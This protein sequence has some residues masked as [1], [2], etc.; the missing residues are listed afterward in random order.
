MKMFEYLY[1]NFYDKRFHHNKKKYIV[2][3]FLA[4]MIIFCVL[5]TLN[6]VSSDLVIASIASSAFVVFSMPHK[7]RSRSRYI[8][9]GYCV[10]LFV[11]LITYSFSLLFAENYPLL[12]HF[13]DEIFGALAVGISIFLMVILDVEHPP[14]AAVALAM[15]INQWNKWTIIVTIVAISLLMLARYYFRDKLIN[16]L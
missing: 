7:V 3:C 8:I 2:Q 1:N 4:T 13:R 14:A 11:G 5:M 16:L 9:G 10:G 6:L 12:Q 15:V